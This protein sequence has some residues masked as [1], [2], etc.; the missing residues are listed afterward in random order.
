MRFV[1]VREPSEMWAVYDQIFDL[2]AEFEGK[3]LGGL[4]RDEAERFAAIANNEI[5]RWRPTPGS[6]KTS[7]SS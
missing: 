4:M 7:M 1:V 3:P 2:P 6:T 5:S